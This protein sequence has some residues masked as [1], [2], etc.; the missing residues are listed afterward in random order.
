MFAIVNIDKNQYKFEPGK[1]YKIDLLDE[2]ASSEKKAVFSDVLL[3]SLDKKT[4]VGTPTIK[5]ASVEADIVAPKL[6]DKK[7][8]VFKFHAKKRY[9]KTAGHRQGYS[10]IKI[11][12][13]NEK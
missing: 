3:I 6:L 8:K 1:E 13:I 10:L 12:K 9:K 7:V 11:T 5:G 2:K 4:A